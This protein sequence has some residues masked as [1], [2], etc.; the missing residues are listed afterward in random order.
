MQATAIGCHCMC[1][2]VCVCWWC[3]GEFNH[4][5]SFF[6]V[7]AVVLGF[8]LQELSYFIYVFIF[9]N[10]MLHMGS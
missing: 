3:G 4:S 6:F 8:F 2:C 5:L 10:I 1:T 7:V 9:G